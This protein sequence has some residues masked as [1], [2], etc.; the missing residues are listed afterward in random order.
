MTTNEKSWHL[1]IL[2]TTCRPPPFK[3]AVIHTKQV[4]SLASFYSNFY[5]HMEFTSKADL[6]KSGSCTA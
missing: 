4:T 2:L 1:G 5:E 3:N 6:T